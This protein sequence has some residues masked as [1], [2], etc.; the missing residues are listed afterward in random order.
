MTVA[1][2]VV[3]TIAQVIEAASAPVALIPDVTTGG[4]GVAASP[5]AIAE[6]AGGEKASKAME[7]TAKALSFVASLLGT[8]AS[9]S[10][11]MA[12]YHRRQEEWKHQENLANLELKQ[13]EK[14]ITGAQI[15]LALAEKE[16]ENHEMQ[17]ENTRKSM[18]TWSISLP[19]KS[20]TTG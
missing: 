15:R 5:V 3:Q 6:V 12:G 16:L 18:I 20:C 9:L 1:S 10:S 19:I 17:M 7:S 11:T 2:S 8:G 13:M 14:Q 4:A